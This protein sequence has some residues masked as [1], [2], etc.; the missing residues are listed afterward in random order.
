MYLSVDI[1]SSVFRCSVADCSRTSAWRCPVEFCGVPICSNHFREYSDRFDSFVVAASSPSPS[2]NSVDSEMESNNLAASSMD[3]PSSPSNVSVSN[4]SLSLVN[5]VGIEETGAVNTQC[6]ETEATNILPEL[7]TEN[8]MAPFH[9]LLNGA[10]NVCRRFESP[11]VM[12]KKYLRFFQ[13]FAAANPGDVLSLIQTESL[14]CPSV[15]FHQESDGAFIGALPYFLYDS[16][17]S[18]NHYGFA[19]FHQ[20]VL[21]R[22]NNIELPVSCNS[23][24]LF[25]LTDVL[26]NVS[27]QSSFTS[28]FFKRGVHN[29]EVKGKQLHSLPQSVNFSLLDSEKNVAELAAAIKTETPAIFLTIT[30]NQKK[31][32]GIA[33]LFNAIQEMFPDKGSELC[34]AAFQLYM[35]ILL[36]MWNNTVNELVD[37]LLNSDEK[38]LGNVIKLWGR[39]EFQS[40]AAN[41]PHYHFLLW[42][43]N[44][45]HEIESLME[46][47]R[48]HFI[49]AFE[50]IFHSEMHLIDTVEELNDI[51]DLCSKIQSHNC[52]NTSGR[53]LKKTDSTGKKICRFQPYAPSNSL[54]L[55]EIPQTY[56]AEAAQILAQLNLIRFIDDWNY[57]VG[58]Q[59]KCEK[60]SYAAD[61]GFQIMPTSPKLFA[62]TKSSSNVQII[63]RNFASKYLNKY[64]AG[65]EE[66]G[67][68]QMKA[69]TADNS[70]RIQQ[71]E[72]QNLK[73]TGAQIQNN[74]S[75]QRERQTSA[76]SALNVSQ[77]EYLWWLLKLPVVIT[78]IEFIHVPSISLENR[79]GKFYR[80]PCSYVLPSGSDG[81]SLSEREFLLFPQH[82]CFTN[83]Q[84]TQIQDASQSNFSTDKVTLFSIRPPEL[85]FVRKLKDHFAFFVR[86]K[87]RI[88]S[89]KV[90]PTLSLVPRPWLDGTNSKI[91]LRSSALHELRI[92]FTQ[93]TGFNDSRVAE[94][95]MV[96]RNLNR[97]NFRE[98]YV[99]DSTMLSTGP[100]EI[101]FSKVYPKNHFKF[102][103]HLL[104]TM[105]SFET[106][107][108]LFSSSSLRNCFVTAGIIPQKVQ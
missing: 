23:K 43:K 44:E 105:G 101:V 67:S 80:R 32:F 55:K 21:A 92:W 108:D 69:G 4:D 102:L 103:L 19:S 5:F 13:N 73:V 63:T 12:L 61:K 104:Y 65:K 30:V 50:K 72:L 77:T 51:I 70:F 22:V 74:T 41:F 38:L 88:H 96:L 97:T 28:D 62:L 66:H 17:K 11:I 47:T 64:A 87:K 52:E 95:E 31:H 68:V 45:R 53:C 6:G 7:E 20:H 42:L 56:S 27:L 99:A 25:Y 35:P 48:K 83:R 106:E 82:N 8:N 60:V 94:F 90:I 76:I 24:Y 10:L 46:S 1:Q 98:V 40:L 100:A 58:E 57:E 85:L 33:P 49:D 36:Q 9:L 18:N 84:K 3:H 14:F 54:W 16:E 107:L 34:K 91:K 86:D 81:N 59:L 37:Y 29:I 71:T 78:N 39:A 93:F 26:L 2:N 89:N 79:G 15:F 75:L